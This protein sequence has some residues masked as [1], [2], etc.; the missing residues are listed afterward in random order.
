MAEDLADG[1][2]PG[3][4]DAE[5][6][7]HAY[8]RLEEGFDLAQVVQEYSLL[9][10]C[11]VRHWRQ[12]SGGLSGTL[13]LDQAIDR[14]VTASVARYARA[15]DRTLQ[16]LDRISA[17]ALES[18]T[19][20]VLFRRLLAVFVETT[21]AVDASAI[22]LREG[23]RLVLR[24]TV[25][26]EEEEK[27]GFA[28]AMGDGFVGLIAAEKVPRFTNEAARDPL[29]RSQALKRQGVRAL[30][31]VPLVDEGEVVGVAHMGSRSAHEFSDL[32]RRLFNAMAERATAGI[33]LHRLRDQAQERAAALHRLEQLISTHPDFFFLID[34][35]HR[36][37]Y[38]SPS[39][40]A[41]W[42]KTQLE[43]AR[44]K[45]FADLNYPPHLVESHRRQLDRVLAGETVRDENP[46]TNPFGKT[47]YYEFILSPIRDPTG[48]VEAVAG[49]SRD[50]SKRR[51]QELELQMAAEF[52]DRF[53][54]ILG[55][56]L[57]SPLMAIKM[58]AT[59]LLAREPNLE[60]VRRGTT[61][62]A[63]SSERMERMIGDMVDLARVRLG[64]GLSLRP[65]GTDLHALCQGLI[66][67]LQAAFPGRTLSCQTSGDCKG[68]W[69][70]DRLAQVISNLAANSL[71]H[72]AE[73]SPVTVRTRGDGDQVVIEVHNFGPVIT[74]ESVA[75]IFEPFRQ[76]PREGDSLPTGHLGLGL[77]IVKQ[78]VKAHGGDIAVDSTPDR[79]TTFRVTL[80]R[81]PRPGGEH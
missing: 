48:N 56:D 16:A 81:H 55:H 72:G 45:T 24:A 74:S 75:R 6:E 68:R 44:G 9:R 7:K 15:R 5:A 31:G 66:D 65:T 58:S 1:I 30:Y 67:E 43:E 10:A 12:E 37:I 21:A 57:R 2:E 8:A 80:P 17:A 28:V 14:A 41:L 70:P 3:P 20:E 32:D 50:I 60:A 53:I 11:V 38:V 69:D 18:P 29:I 34:R 71:Q 35:D 76:A 42:G 33:R 59:T 77:Y 25:G 19:L 40:L 79:G 39:L 26:L 61:R 62:I 54:G 64:G 51:Q 73:T 13:L 23:E 4:P 49:V 27:Q 47:G 63:R 22:F 46:Y 52:R 78:I 36:F